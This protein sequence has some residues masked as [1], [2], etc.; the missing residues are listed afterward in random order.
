[1]SN[2]HG[3]NTSFAVSN[4]LMRCCFIAV[5]NFVHCKKAERSA[6]RNVL[7]EH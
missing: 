5:Q 3:T 4:P 6:I 1:M 2:Y 7:K